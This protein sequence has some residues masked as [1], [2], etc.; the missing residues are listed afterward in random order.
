MAT[1]KDIAN[2]VKRLQDDIVQVGGEPLHAT[3]L[4]AYFLP[5]KVWALVKVAVDDPNRYE[6]IYTLGDTKGEAET[7]LLALR[8]GVWLA[9]RTMWNGSLGESAQLS[10]N[11]ENGSGR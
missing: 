4:D 7:R 10:T 9:Q 8:Q 1:A 5:T 2:Q 11:H 6:V 3:S